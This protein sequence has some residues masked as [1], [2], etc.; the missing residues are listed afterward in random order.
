[1]RPGEALFRSFSVVARRRRNKRRSEIV[2]A[3]TR[4][5]PRA[6]VYGLTT[7]GLIAFDIAV[8]LLA[9]GNLSA[10]LALFTA[11]GAAWGLARVL[12]L[13]R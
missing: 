4:T 11:A 8:L 3:V 9:L 13:R 5:A 7:V 2:N 1:M 10:A 12:V 6:A